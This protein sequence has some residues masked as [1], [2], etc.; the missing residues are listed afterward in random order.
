MCCAL[1]VCHRS[2]QVVC[3]LVLC[4]ATCTCRDDTPTDAVLSP[5]DTAARLLHAP[6]N[7]QEKIK[8]EG[9]WLALALPGN[10][11]YTPKICYVD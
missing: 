4:D 6:I 9:D 8:S 10:I 5:V 2:C 1:A 11:S 3:V 7:I